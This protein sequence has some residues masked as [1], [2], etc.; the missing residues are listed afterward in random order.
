MFGPNTLTK[1]SVRKH[2]DLVKVLSGR[3]EAKEVQ[4]YYEHLKGMFDAPQ[5]DETFG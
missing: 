5:V 4:A 2:Q 1:L 3:M